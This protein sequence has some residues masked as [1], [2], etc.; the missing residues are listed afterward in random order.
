MKDGMEA[1]KSIKR[2][3]TKLKKLAKKVKANRY[4][5]TNNNHIFAD[6]L[7]KQRNV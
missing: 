2:L 1:N 7:R 6:L 3:Y 4:T 5:Q